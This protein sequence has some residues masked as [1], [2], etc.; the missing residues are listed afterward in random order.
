MEYTLKEKTS[1]LTGAALKWIAIIT[2]L[3][4]HIGAVVLMPYIG[5]AG[6]SGGN[7]VDIETLRQIYTICRMIGRVSFP[8]FC[9]LIVEGFIHTRDV[10]KYAL[11]LG[12]F[13]IISEI[14]FDLSLAGVFFETG[15]QNIFF[16]L[17][18]GLVVIIGFHRI[19][20]KNSIVA[21]LIPLAGA[22]L[23]EK[24]NTDYGAFGV[25]LIFL[26]YYFRG[27]QIQRAIAIFVLIFLNFTWILSKVGLSPAQVNL[28]YYI[29]TALPLTALIPIGFYNGL[30]GKQA[31][32]LFYGFYPIHLL[33]LYF[34]K[35]AIIAG[36]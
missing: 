26:F 23:A 5:A 33:I 8:L 12:I 20:E 4:D 2:M 29:Q 13:A 11:R 27:K 35:N 34:I 36:L 1:G 17:F 15:N 31:K 9:F 19:K 32:Y 25:L 3:I 22:V 30:R 18:I 16:T 7:T 14:P 21:F 6:F 24:L 10:K 28:S